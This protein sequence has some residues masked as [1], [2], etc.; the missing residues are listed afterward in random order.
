MACGSYN[1]SIPGRRS[2]EVMLNASDFITKY[3]SW[4][5]T[6]ELIAFKAFL[7]PAHGVIEQ[8]NEYMGHTVTH[9]SDNE[10]V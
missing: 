7:A 1:L 6:P 4:F 9:Y 2:G 8:Y 5:S 3:Q 10:W